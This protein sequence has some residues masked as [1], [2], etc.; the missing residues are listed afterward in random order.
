[1]QDQPTSRLPLYKRGKLVAYATVDADLAER[2]LLF[3]WREHTGYAI[4]GG[5][6]KVWLHHFV[7]GRPAKGYVTDHI[8]GDGFDNRPTNLRIV[9]QAI[10]MQNRYS[11]NTGSS[12]RY[13]RV[14]WDNAR[15]KWVGRV[16]VNRRQYHVGIFDDEDAAGEAVAA[17][18][19]RL[20]PG[21]PEAR[22]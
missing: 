2:A 20:M 12:S 18:R 8:N 21:S 9:T 7:A 13:R 10:N 3:H 11:G 4:T 5:A 6:R 1:M 15:G 17:L 22:R 14:F 19:A 16:Q